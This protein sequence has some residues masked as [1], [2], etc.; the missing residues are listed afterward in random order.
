[1]NN[2]R[3]GDQV[4]HGTV[5]GV[6]AGADDAADQDITGHG[7]TAALTDMVGDVPGP[8]LVTRLGDGDV[9]FRLSQH[10]HR[11]RRGG[12]GKAVRRGDRGTAWI[13]LDDK[14]VVRAARHGGAA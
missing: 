3:I 7:A 12:A 13:G 1:M 11:A 14:G 10:P 6:N 2:Q 9:E 5:A 4:E 8:G